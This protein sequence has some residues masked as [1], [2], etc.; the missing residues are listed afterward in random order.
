MIDGI[1]TKNINSNDIFIDR[2]N[3][4]YVIDSQNKRVYKWFDFNSTNAIFHQF[5]ESTDTLFVSTTGDIYVSA[6][7]SSEHVQKWTAKT[8]TI[9]ISMH[10]CGG[11]SSIFIDANDIFYCAIK[12]NHQIVTTSINN[13]STILTVVAGT[14]FLGSESN[15][16][17]MPEG[18]FVDT[19]L[20]LYVADS[21]NNRIQLFHPGDLNGKTIAGTSDSILLHLP[22]RVL[23][24]EDGVIYILHLID[25]CLVRSGP[26][27][28]EPLVICEKFFFI[29]NYAM[30]F[31]IYGNIYSISMR[32][33]TPIVKYLL[34][35][36]TCGK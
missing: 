6:S 31:D 22:M 2:N 17:H 13:N 11:C 23:L 35:K 8:N 21:G 14:G 18:I 25:P 5:N 34:I 36:N 20:D 7:G 29:F 19:N 27:G 33:T 26:K 16:L 32:P 15:M 24:D 4:I 9:N 10:I 30:T 28:Y 12:M 1:L 3:T